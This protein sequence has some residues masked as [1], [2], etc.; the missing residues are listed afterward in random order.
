MI[1]GSPPLTGTAKL[2]HEWSDFLKL[3]LVIHARATG[4]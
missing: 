2:S 4:T 1:P 3:A